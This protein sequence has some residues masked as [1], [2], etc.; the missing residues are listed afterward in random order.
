[1]KKQI[2]VIDFFG[3]IEYT[4]LSERSA[5][6]KLEELNSDDV[7]Y[8]LRSYDIEDFDEVILEYYKN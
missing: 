3:Y 5:I 1:M 8:V 2:H 7:G 6:N 4:F